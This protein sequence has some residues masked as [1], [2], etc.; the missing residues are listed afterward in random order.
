MTG[1]DHQD[2]PVQAPAVDALPLL[3]VGAWFA[4]LTLAT[5]GLRVTGGGRPIDELGPAEVFPAYLWAQ[6]ITVGLV[7]MVLP[8]VLPGWRHWLGMSPATG[9]RLRRGLRDFLVV[10]PLWWVAMLAYQW[11]VLTPL[12]VEPEQRALGTALEGL[13]GPDAG[14]AV[15]ALTLCLRRRSARPPSR[16]HIHAGS[17]SAWLRGRVPMQVAAADRPAVRPRA[18][19]GTSAR[20]MLVPRWPAG[21]SSVLGA[22]RRSDD[23]PAHSSCTRSA[24]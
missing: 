20:L 3:I 18:H 13:T 16:A 21:L 23:L 6:G 19:G 11:L 7:F 2:R 14:P 17:C 12:S 5:I 24:A 4:F 9:W 22:R 8:R 1:T 10:A 15:I